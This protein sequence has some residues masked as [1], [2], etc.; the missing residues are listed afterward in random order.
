MSNIETFFSVYF[1]DQK[2]KG[3]KFAIGKYHNGNIKID[4]Y[5]SI[6]DV[7]VESIELRGLGYF[8][9]FSTPLS[10]YESEIRK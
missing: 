8:Y 4:I 2:T 7:I 5:D 6:M 9:N 1:F 10:W 3:P